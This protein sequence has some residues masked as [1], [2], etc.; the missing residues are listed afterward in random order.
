MNLLS[1][2]YVCQC[3]CLVAVFVFGM[4]YDCLA[5][6]GGLELFSGSGFCG[7]KCDP[8][9]IISVPDKGGR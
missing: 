1:R 2:F 3:K 5:Y 6:L 4:L 9:L 8:R 7:T